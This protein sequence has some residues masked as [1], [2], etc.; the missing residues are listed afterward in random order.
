MQAEPIPAPRRARRSIGERLRS[1]ILAL[2]GGHGDVQHHAEKAWAS[3]TFAGTRHTLRLVFEGDEAVAQGEALV[4][5]LPNHEFAIPRQLVADATITAV[6]SELLPVPR[7]LVECEL[8][9]LED[10]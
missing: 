10:V 4:A 9:L 2:A 3:I 6:E 8:L 5:A 7:M 1:A